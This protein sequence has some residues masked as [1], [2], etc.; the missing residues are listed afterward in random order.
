MHTQWRYPNRK[1]CKQWGSSQT[2]ECPTLPFFS[3]YNGSSDLEHVKFNKFE[4]A[5][6]SYNKLQFLFAKVKTPYLLPRYKLMNALNKWGRQDWTTE[7]FPRKTYLLWEW[8]HSCYIC[9]GHFT[10]QM[11]PEV[12]K[13]CQFN[14]RKRLGTSDIQLFGQ[15]PNNTSS[16][17]REKPGG[18][19]LNK[20]FVS[21][22]YLPLPSRRTL[23][24]WRK[25]RNQKRTEQPTPTPTPNG[26]LNSMTSTSVRVS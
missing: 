7:N 1:T 21:Q 15:R 25:I 6:E 20:N 13:T 22:Y 10:L 17:L 14:Q 26:D 19:I 23:Q 24:S 3:L 4:V 11:F 2:C 18:S 16:L 12:E 5:T 8:H 9:R